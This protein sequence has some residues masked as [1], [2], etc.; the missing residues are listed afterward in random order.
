[1]VQYFFTTQL[2]GFFH[3]SHF[4]LILIRTHVAQIVRRR[5][6]GGKRGYVV[7]HILLR[8]EPCLVIPPVDSLL[9]QTPE[10]AFR[11]VFASD[12]IVALAQSL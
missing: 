3:F 7:Q 2:S 1:M 11:N 9:L 10:E 4:R 6:V 12:K 8:V 5:F